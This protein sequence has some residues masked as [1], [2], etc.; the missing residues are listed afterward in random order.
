MVPE[1]YNKLLRRVLRNKEDMEG[2]VWRELFWEER[3]NIV[4]VIT[5]F[6]DAGRWSCP[7][8]IIFEYDGKHYRIWYSQGLTECQD[9]EWETQAAEEVHLVEVVRQEWQSV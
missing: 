2:Y 8:D 3:I 1:E 6:D 4:E 9:D 5:H 7:V